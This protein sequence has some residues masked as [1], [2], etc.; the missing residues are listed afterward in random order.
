MISQYPGR[1]IMSR[2]IYEQISNYRKTLPPYKPLSHEE[3]AGLASKIAEG[4]TNSRNK[5]I[6]SCL[7][8]VPTIAEEFCERNLPVLDLIAE[9]NIGLIIA[10]QKFDPSKGAKLSSYAA[11]WIKR[12]MWR[13]IAEQAGT[14]RIPF[15]AANY[16]N[17]IERARVELLA[18][19]GEEPT[20]EEIAN[21]LSITGE[22][23]T[24]RVVSNHREAK[25]SSRCVHLEEIRCQESGDVKDFED[26]RATTPY[27]AALTRDCETIRKF[28][29]SQI[30]I[31]KIEAQILKM[32]FGIDSEPMTYEQI[33]KIIKR[34]RE[35]AR[36]AYFR[37]LHKLRK[38]I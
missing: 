13:A 20:N 16:I 29:E 2:K 27:E 22:K 30:G 32:R 38:Y 6:E 33:S 34:T 11:W 8:L 15:Q 21:H 23:F 18:K 36:K 24:A 1:G 37:A 31:T 26:S 3:E 7:H 5:L 35:G 25:K 4:D 17:R 10:A 9:G 19:N 14:M 12:E 28:L